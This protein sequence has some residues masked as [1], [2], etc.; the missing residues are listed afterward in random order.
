MP[1]ARSDFLRDLEAAVAAEL[2]IELERTFRIGVLIAMDRTTRQI[3]AELGVTTV[4]VRRARE[5]LR[6]SLERAGQ[7]TELALP[8]A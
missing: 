4:D 6:R 3:C 1:R 5:L 2:R 7:S 8:A